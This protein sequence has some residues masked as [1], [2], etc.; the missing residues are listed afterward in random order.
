MTTNLHSDISKDPITLTHIKEKEGK[1][2]R[3]K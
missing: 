1:K 2:E 3:K